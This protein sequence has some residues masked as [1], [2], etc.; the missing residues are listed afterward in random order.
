MTYFDIDPYW[1][2]RTLIFYIGILLLCGGLALYYQ[3]RSVRLGRLYPVQLL[4]VGILLPILILLFIKGFGTT[5]RDIRTGYYMNYCSAESMYSFYDKSLEAGYRLL[6]VLC[7]NLGF[8]YQAFLFLIAVITLF[9]VMLI[10]NKYRFEIDM[11]SAILMYIGIFFYAGF[12]PVRIAMASSLGLIAF[13]AMVEQKPIKSFIWIVIASQFHV[14]ALVLLAPLVI[15]MIKKLSNKTI[16]AGA[17]IVLILV[18]FCRNQIMHFLI[19]SNERYEIYGAFAE[20][21]IGM[22]KFAYYI[23]MFLVLFLGKKYDR[24]PCILKLC[25]VYLTMLFCFDFMEYFVSILGR[26]RDIFLPIIIL[27]PYYI[28]RLKLRYPNYKKIISAC[29]VGYCIIRVVVLCKDYYIGY[30]IMPYTNY[31]GWVI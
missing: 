2:N 9:P 13:D 4:N 16:V 10:I 17:V 22:Q 24:N 31:M 27:I 23:P 29:V 21:S 19:S 5:G 6:N 14:T 12:S 1:S 3:R 8:S 11:P 30:D 26:F 20:V 7:Y 28:K 15:L 18:Y 25:T